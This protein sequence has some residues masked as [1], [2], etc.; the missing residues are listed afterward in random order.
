MENNEII[1]YTINSVEGEKVES[2]LREYGLEST[3]RHI[4]RDS[5]TYED[6]KALLAL[7]DNG[8]D[9][10]LTQRGNA[11]D[12]LEEDGLVLDDLTLSQAFHVILQNPKLLKTTIIT[13]G[14]KIAYGLNGT[15]M[16]LSRDVRRREQLALQRKAARLERKELIERGD[17]L[18]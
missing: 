18:A 13:N 10:L 11:I 14:S 8:L 9:D 2:K 17:L 7:T 6:F 1:V 12:Y 3:T 15:K 5:F 4:I 16:F